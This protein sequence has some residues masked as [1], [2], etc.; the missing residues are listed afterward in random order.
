MTPE[1]VKTTLSDADVTERFV[2]T[3]LDVGIDTLIELR[4]RG[5]SIRHL[6]FEER[7]G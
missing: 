3:H 6:R 5:E 4:D 7:P 2:G 1:G